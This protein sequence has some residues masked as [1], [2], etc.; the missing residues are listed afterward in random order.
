MVESVICNVSHAAKTTS[1]V[2]Q[3]LESGLN[4][5]PHLDTGTVASVGHGDVVD[6]QILHD[7]SLAFVLAQRTNTDTM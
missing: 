5:R 2:Q 7:I 4:T 1:S 6:I 3:T